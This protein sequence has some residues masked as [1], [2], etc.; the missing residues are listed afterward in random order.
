MQQKKPFKP[1]NLRTLLSVLLAI[2]V[3]GG[4]A[5]FYFGLGIVKEYAV[6]VDHRLADADASAQQIQGLQTLQ[7]QLSESNSLVEKA[8][9]LFA[10]PDTYQSQALN[11]IKQYADLAGIA[12]N[13]TSMDDTANGTHTVTVTLKNPVSFA[14]FVN[15]LNNIEG[16]LPKL[17]VSSLSL[18][19]AD[20]ND[21]DKVQVSE[22]KIDVLVR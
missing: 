18:S 12:I 5:L 6:E 15:F 22:I 4:G 2:I 8:D 1:Q 20:G 13:G 19:H 21:P 14:A 11:D 3:I 10:T 9:R 16:N 7:G 17:Q